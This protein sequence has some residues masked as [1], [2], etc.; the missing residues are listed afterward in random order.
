MHSYLNEN[1]CYVFAPANYP[2]SLTCSLGSVFNLRQR[3]F[4][5]V[6]APNI[7][8]IGDITDIKLP[9]LS[10]IPSSISTTLNSSLLGP[11]FKPAA[12]ST[13]DR[14]STATDRHLYRSATARLFGGPDA[15]AEVIRG[16]S[17]TTRRG[18]NK[19]EVVVP[20]PPIIASRGG[21]NTSFSGDVSGKELLPAALSEVD[22][23]FRLTIL[24]SSGHCR[25]RVF[26]F[27]ATSPKFSLRGSYRSHWV[28]RRAVSNPR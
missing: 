5:T 7:S 23:G 27:Y 20:L 21:T 19:G 9:N 4:G 12:F 18:S 11:P 15:N 1:Q 2:L 25:L 16:R 24:T 14:P 28:I 8:Q 13:T 10:L 3:R 22:I 26:L 6:Q 17:L